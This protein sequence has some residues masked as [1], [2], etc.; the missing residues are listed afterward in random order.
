M[1]E[2]GHF[3]GSQERGEKRNV[4]VFLILGSVAVVPTHP[5]LHSQHLGVLLAGGRRR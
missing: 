1:P 4:P 5:E 3:N 2:N